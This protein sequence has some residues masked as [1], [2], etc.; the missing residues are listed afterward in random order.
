VIAALW[1]WLGHRNSNPPIPA[2]FGAGLVFLSLGFVLISAG[3]SFAAK[4]SGVGPWWL[5]GTYFL[6][7]VGELCLSP[8]GLSSITK[9]AP[10]RF[11]GQMMGVW[12]LGTSLGN[13]IAG[14]TAGSLKTGSPAELSGGFLQIAIAPAIAGVL[15]IALARPISRLSANVR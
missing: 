8:V 2:K 6:H 10:E 9:L 12:F 14:L 5:V 13:L 4:W 15:L 11:V 7:T 3:A 1:V